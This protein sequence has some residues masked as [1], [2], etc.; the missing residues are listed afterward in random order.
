MKLQWV[1]WNAWIAYLFSVDVYS[2]GSEGSKLFNCEIHDMVIRKT[3]LGQGE[4]WIKTVKCVAVMHC[5]WIHHLLDNHF[6]VTWFK[7]Y[8]YYQSLFHLGLILIWSSQLSATM[9]ISKSIS[10]FLYVKQNILIN[11]MLR[12][13]KLCL[14]FLFGMPFLIP[15]LHQLGWIWLSDE[16]C[17]EVQ[18]TNIQMMCLVDYQNTPLFLHLEPTLVKLH[19]DFQESIEKSVPQPKHW[20]SQFEHEIPK[21]RIIWTYKRAILN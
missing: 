1:K 11:E 17:P 2:N 12:W 3:S 8:S 16:T 6:K 7:W 9:I 4:F 19:V 15:G 5:H 13:N 10:F 14:R 21:S 20:F 18:V